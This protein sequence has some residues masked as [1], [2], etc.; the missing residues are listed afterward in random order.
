MIRFIRNNE[1]AFKGANTRRRDE[2][3]EGMRVVVGCVRRVIS[4]FYRFFM[5]LLLLLLLRSILQKIG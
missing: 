3:T 2:K 4:F 5:T 1:R